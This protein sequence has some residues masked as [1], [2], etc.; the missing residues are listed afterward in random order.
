MPWIQRG[1]RKFFYSYERDKNGKLQ[2]TYVAKSSSPKAIEAEKEEQKHKSQKKED[3]DSI[4]LFDELISEFDAVRE[5]NDWLIR[6]TLIT[7]GYYKNTESSKIRKLSHD[8]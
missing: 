6:Y 8:N 4:N 3:K 2:K 1:K 5:R 7:G